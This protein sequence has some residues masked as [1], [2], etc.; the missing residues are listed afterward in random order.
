MV[1]TK[2]NTKSLDIQLLGQKGDVI[3]KSIESFIIVVVMTCRGRLRFI[4]LIQIK[5]R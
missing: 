3:S 4:R 5:E 1:H 2:T